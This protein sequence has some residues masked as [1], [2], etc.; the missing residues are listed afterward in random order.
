MEKLGDNY[1]DEKNFMYSRNNV[2]PSQAVYLRCMNN[3]KYQCPARVILKVDSAVLTIRHSHDADRKHVDKARFFNK[4]CENIK[5]DPFEKPG[6]IYLTAKRQMLELTEDPIDEGSIPSAKQVRSYIDSRIKEQIPRL[7][8]T[9]EEF[10]NFVAQD[11]YG[12][13]FAIDCG[14]LAFY[15]GVWESVK[16]EKSVAFVSETVL[17]FVNTQNNVALFM[18]GTFRALPYHI[19]FGQLYVINY[20]YKNHC[21]PLA[22]VLMK[23]CIFTAY[24]TI[25]SNIKLLMPSVVVAKLMT[26]YEAAARK[27][28]RISFPDARL[29]GCFF[30]YAQAI[31]KYAHKCNLL[32]DAKFKLAVRKVSVLALLPN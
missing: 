21:Y 8:K 28:L 16:G 2:G 23:K 13:R 27:A 15:R 17:K 31:Y 19:K 14:Q 22:Y 5:F 25:F 26:D 32:D 12:K 1:R 7:P 20:I 9:V 24:D 30:H 18:D 6:K 4:L 10:D 11:K 3:V 29:A